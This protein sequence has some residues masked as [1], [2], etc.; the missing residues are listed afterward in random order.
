M[1]SLKKAFTNIRR[2]PYQAIAAILVLSITFF[3]VIIVSFAS[4]AIYQAL[5]FFETRPQVLIFFQ[6]DAK[7]SE[8]DAL[9]VKL[10]Q[11]PDVSNITYI[12]QDQALDIYQELNKNDPLLLELV[13]ADI[14]P[15]SLE[16]ST[17]N[18]ESLKSVAALSSEAPG[19][20]EV[21]LRSDVVDILNKWLLGIRIAGLSFIVILTITSILI[22]GIVV[23]MKIASRNH[24][25]QIMQL[26][27]ASLWYIQGP[28]LLEGAVYGFFSSL[29]ANFI[30]I[31]LLLYSTPVILEFS[32][33]VPL[34]PNSPVI[35]L[36][37][38]A[39]ST[40]SGIFIG[41]LGSWLAVKRFIHR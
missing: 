40:L 39:G 20:D 4:V 37:I 35:L 1:K 6:S 28:Y 16:I 5:S 30:A 12:P 36:L 25:I 3:V 13:S 27:G 26:I 38:F 19:V 17:S 7:D 34:L 9:K 33:D 31:I 10:S 32:G 2:R 11:S 18:L 14:L 23:G 8:I 15:A 24:E 21:V 22:I 29:I 41:I